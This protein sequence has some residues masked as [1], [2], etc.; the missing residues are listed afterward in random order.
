MTVICTYIIFN[1][2][3]DTWNFFLSA[4]KWFKEQSFSPL[5]K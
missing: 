4:E 3:Q 5:F 2:I 1:Y